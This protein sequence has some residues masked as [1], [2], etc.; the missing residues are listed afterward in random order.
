[1]ETIG[2]DTITH[3]RHTDRQHLG[4]YTLLS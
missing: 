3:S 1:M 2:L 4:P